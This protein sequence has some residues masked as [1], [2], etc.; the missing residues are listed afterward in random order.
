MRMSEEQTTRRTRLSAP[1][2][3]MATAMAPAAVALWL[4]I[5]LTPAGTMLEATMTGHVLVEIPLLVAVGVVLGARVEPS[6]WRVLVPLNSG[7]IP[8]VLI[9]TFALAFW[10]IPRWLD[11][12]LSDPVVAF[13]KYVSL[14]VLVGMP[15]AWS[16]RRMHPIARGVVKIEFLSMLFRLGWL[17]LISPERLCNNYL[18]GD[19]LWLGRGFLVVGVALS[20]AWLVPLFFDS[21]PS[22]RRSPVM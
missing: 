2:M 1:A 19:Q 17:Y 4:L 12:A 20:V 11:A 10:M 7:G 8:G 9:A 18:L 15:L 6:L 13:A 3:A 16:W 21:H 22:R 5:A 14:P